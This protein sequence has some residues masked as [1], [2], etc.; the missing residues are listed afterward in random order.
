MKSKNALKSFISPTFLVLLLTAF[1]TSI[2]YSCSCAD[3]SVRQKFRMSDLVF[4]GQVIDYT[5]APPTKEAS[6][7][8]SVTLKVEKQWKGA[9]K[10][11]IKVWWGFDS[12]GMCNDL[13]LVKGEKYLIYTNREKDGYGGVEPDCGTNYRAKYHEKEIEQLDKFWFRFYARLFPFPNI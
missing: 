10:P 11:E 3:P 2:A 1:S 7:M 4:V 9:K 13:S 12:P 8:Y 5:D 6:V